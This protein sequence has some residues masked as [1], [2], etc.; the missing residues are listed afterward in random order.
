MFANWLMNDGIINRQKLICIVRAHV[1]E[2]VE[3]N[4]EVRVVEI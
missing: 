1:A 4:V 3:V 2:L